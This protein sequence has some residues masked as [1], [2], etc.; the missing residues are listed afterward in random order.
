[1]VSKIRVVS[2]LKHKTLFNLSYITVLIIKIKS[3]TIISKRCWGYG[4]VS[5]RFSSL[6][7]LTIATT[8]FHA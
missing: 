1:M 6:N 7:I 4:I 5:F 2:Q 3:S 8:Q